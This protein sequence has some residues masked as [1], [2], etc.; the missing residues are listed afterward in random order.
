VRGGGVDPIP[1]V[2]VAEKADERPAARRP[3]QLVG[4]IR[5]GATIAI[6][7]YLVLTLLGATTSSIGL[8]QLRSNADTSHGTQI[9]T[10][11][12]IRSDEWLTITPI[13]LG[14]LAS[15]SDR[16]ET[17][18]ATASD[19]IYQLP[20]GSLP[21]SIVFFDGNLFK[22]GDVFPQRMLF[23][24]WWWLPTLLLVLAMPA[25][26]RR[27]GA[28]RNLAWLATGLTVLA[29]ATAWWSLFPDRILGFLVAGCYLLIR[30]S[31]SYYGGRRAQALGLAA[32]AGVLFSRLPT[33]Y[34]PWSL[35]IGVPVLLATLA[36]LVWPPAS[37]RASLIVIGCAGAVAVGLFGLLVLENHAA[38]SAAI[39]TVYPGQ[40]RSTGRAINAA[41]RFGAPL[42]G[43]FRTGSLARRINVSELSSAYTVSGVLALVVWA[44]TKRRGWDRER[45]AIAVL[46]VSAVLWLLW[47]SIPMG[48][49][50][51]HVP[52]FNRVPAE[53]AAQTVGYLA[54]IMLALVLSRTD[55]AVRARVTVAAAL[56]C[57]GVTLIGALALH[58]LMPKL[59]WTYVVITLVV[60][61]ILAYLITTFRDRTWPVVVVLVVAVLQVFSVNPLIFGFGDL[62]SSTAAHVV[63]NLGR[64]G[65][66]AYWVSDDPTVDALFIA[67][68]V[69]LL[70]GHQVTGPDQSEW[71]K[72]DPTSRYAH[73]WNRGT[74]YVGFAWTGNQS[75][76]IDS[77]HKDVIDVIRVRVDPCV[78][79]GLGI[80]IAGIVSL[81]PQ[82]GSC[83]APMGTFE[84]GGSR[85]YVYRNT[86]NR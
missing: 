48:H 46:T 51:K 67:N 19:Y 53:R 62:R 21:E 32:V 59:S 14:R 81:R 85:R 15:G 17:P 11:R 71:H 4:W 18:L 27:L 82:A 37:R 39:H 60:V 35:T 9:G 3:R 78:L 63:Q 56:A 33:F 77:P 65:K 57:A 23:A 28:S 16:A 22:L 49:L 44:G 54:V 52:I 68:G 31:D 40:R 80:P 7:A 64:Q 25:W 1:D 43:V 61:A 42:F 12:S 6:L 26:L 38:I 34:V 20:N 74:S 76:I 24:A 8:P 69:P 30:A 66:N 29:P 41:Q 72:L 86:Q 83:L 70:S 47:C 55:G 5:P 73:A 50:G 45:V 36:W 58:P 79:T 2:D 84:W 75:P 13:D 10:A